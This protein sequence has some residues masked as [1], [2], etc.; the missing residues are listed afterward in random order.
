MPTHSSIHLSTYMYMYLHIHPHCSFNAHT[1]SI[2]PSIYPSLHLHVFTHP[3]TFFIQFLHSIHPSTYMYLH[4]HPHSS[5]NAHTPSIHPFHSYTVSCLQNK[6][7]II[8]IE[9]T[10]WPNGIHEKARSVHALHCPQ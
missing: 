6:I 7:I 1:P 9:D 2:H 10:R 5:F 3:S 8:T 4:I